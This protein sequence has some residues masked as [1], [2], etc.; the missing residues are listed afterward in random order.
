LSF[1]SFELIAKEVLKLV[2]SKM[3][4]TAASI[5]IFNEDASTIQLKYVSDS[6]I[7]RLTKQLILGKDG[8]EPIR[9]DQLDILTK[10]IEAALDKEVKIGNDIVDFACPP[11]S[12]NVARVLQAVSN[13]N[14]II[15]LPII[16]NKKV[17][18]VLNFSSSKKN[19]QITE[20]EIRT[21]KSFVNQIGLIVDNAQKYE[22]I[23]HFNVDLKRR[24]DIATQDLIK[25]NSDLQSLYNLTSKVSTSL[26]PEQVAQ[27]AVNSLPQDK[28]IIG[29]VISLFDEK[30]NT[31]TP[32][33]ATENELS[34]QVKKLTGE[35][36]NLG[37]KLDDQASQENLAIRAFLE[38]K[39]IYTD[40][41]AKYLS[42]VVFA[43]II[44]RV[45]KLIN[46]KSIAIHPI[47]WKGQTRGVIAFLIKDKSA[48]EIQDSEKQLL[49]TYTYHISIALENAEL[50]KKQRE[51]QDELERALQEV[52]ALR[53]HEQDMVDIMGHELRTP[54]TIVRNSLG[55]MDMELKNKGKIEPANLSKFLDIAMESARREVK[56]VETLLSSAKADSKGFQLLFE[57]VDL[58]DVIQDSLVLFKKEGEK[59]GLK[60]LF[61]A[62]Q[63]DHFVYSDRVRTQ[64]IVDNLI[65]N[66]VKYTEKGEV[67]ISI[68]KE[69]GY[70]WVDIK[71]SGIGIS[72][73]DKKSL[74]QKFYRVDQY[75]DEKGEIKNEKRNIIR[76]GG[77][78]LGLYVTFSLIT[79]MDGEHYV[80]SEIGKGST[81]SFKLPEFKGQ[82]SKQ[83]QRKV[84]E[85]VEQKAAV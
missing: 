18:A 35:F 19:E 75:I 4:Y 25:Q 79:L 39:K 66:A 29:S 40:D 62:P 3:G 6:L 13:M 61:E 83:E 43:N 53:Q 31:L 1:D 42:P 71:D 37:A 21:L 28:F 56:L 16:A 55:V 24:I 50:Y 81:F 63:G 58:I 23:S 60:V 8:F 67:E 2:E 34:H 49:D 64:E 22:E 51:I 15:A 38:E 14:T 46:V 41:V 85:E 59:K 69:E 76:P 72:D 12:K 78:G 77:T 54:I 70:V 44:N 82:E 52:Q 36:T 26:E 73:E 68:R 84:E 11:M 10:T 20:N 27:T 65:G 9:Y 74:G 30:T 57:K 33:A 45:L 47:Q 7:A 17:I 32:L 48:E 80:E 5:S